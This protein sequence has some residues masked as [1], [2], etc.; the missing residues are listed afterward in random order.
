[1]HVGSWVTFGA[2]GVCCCL[3]GQVEEGG[4]EEGACEGASG[5]GRG[6]GSSEGGNAGSACTGGS[7]LHPPSSACL[8]APCPGLAPLLTLVRLIKQRVP[9]MA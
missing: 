7:S 3:K 6:L 8:E 2:L 5:G 9:G 4:R 1:M